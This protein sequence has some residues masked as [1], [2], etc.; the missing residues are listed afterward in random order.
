MSTD[1]SQE[2]DLISRFQPR[3]TSLLQ[4]QKTVLRPIQATVDITLSVTLLLTITFLGT[5]GVDL[6]YRLLSVIVVL[7]MLGFYSYFGVY[8]F[9]TDALHMVVRLT[10]A[11]AAVVFCL[12]LIGFV[13]KTSDSVSRQVILTWIITSY[14][15]QILVHVLARVVVRNLHAHQHRARQPALLIGANPLGLYLTHRINNNPW[16][17]IKVIGVIDDDNANLSQ[18]NIPDVPRLGGTQELQRLL[19]IHEI[20]SV[21]IA[22]P[23]DRSEIIAKLYAYLEEKNVNI[24]W[25]PD[26][27]EFRL[28][29]PSVKELGGVPLLT[30]SETPLL[31][32]HKWVKYVE[33][34]V[35]AILALLAISP[36]M[37]LAGLAIKLDSRGPI[38][39]KQRRHGWDGRIIEVWKFRT[40]Y[41]SETTS[42]NVQQATKD[43]PR[44]T[45]V[46]R[47][48]R[49][50]SI[51]EL[52]QL[53]NVLQGSMSLVGPRPHAVE[54]NDYYSKK[55]QAYLSR[56]RIKPG[57]TGFAQVQ[58]FRGETDT[59][60][61]ME[62][63]VAYD[64]KYI[65]E[66]SLWLD[67]WIL[68]KTVFTLFSK[69]AY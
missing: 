45:R 10:K 49:R 38:I 51:D 37:L 16:L 9:V 7:L 57:I 11:W 56:H 44:I 41:A 50:T 68:F 46:G 1:V 4:R 43:D 29:N 2:M 12:F 33:D 14:F 18:W 64:L 67:L 8:R 66:W 27:H 34:K 6:L 36:L 58:G 3:K 62:G 53:F 20:V 40:M 22:L 21:Y 63:R 59:L 28:I 42:A 30:L 23:L 61:K 25:A 48:L 31:G 13:T 32:T 47:I 35:L 26:I 65:N 60:E 52:P 15:A 69:N 54:H 55:I 19:H 5:G 39:F 24:Y 17:G